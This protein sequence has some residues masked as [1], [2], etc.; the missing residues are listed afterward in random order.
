[1]KKLLFVAAF[2]CFSININAQNDEAFTNDTTKLVEMLTEYAFKPVIAQFSSMVSEENKT[3]FLEELDLTFPYLYVSM[4]K[5]YM[6]E[7]T[8]DEVLALIAFYETP[9][10]KKLADKSVELAQKG[11]AAGQ[12]WGGK[13]QEI[14]AKYQ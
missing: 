11:M 1:M 5:I 14:I 12:I 7:F 9:V 2:I 6:E 13:V 3:A 10:G 4:A 8:H